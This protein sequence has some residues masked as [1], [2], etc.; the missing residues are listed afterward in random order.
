MSDVIELRVALTVQD[1]EE[2]VAFY[3]DS[4]G[5]TQLEDWSSDIGRVI[6]L[7]GGKATLE[8]LDE[9]QAAAVDEIEV[10]ARVSGTVR[11]ALEVADSQMTSRRLIAAGAKEMAPPILTPWGDR[12]ARV[13]APDGMQ[14]TLFSSQ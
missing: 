10:G 1:F 2:A 5:L 4:L 3:R 11:I 14:L 7:D 9:A 8:L 13:R 6:L 12:N